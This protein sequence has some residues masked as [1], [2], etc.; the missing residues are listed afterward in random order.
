MSHRARCSVILRAAKRSRSIGRVS[1]YGQGVFAR[2]VWQVCQDA[3]QSSRRHSRLRR[4]CRQGF[5][6]VLPALQRTM[7]LGEGWSGLVGLLLRDDWK[8]L[9]TAAFLR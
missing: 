3:P 7:T 5:A 9:L 1:E 6:P 8:L 2:S 4:P